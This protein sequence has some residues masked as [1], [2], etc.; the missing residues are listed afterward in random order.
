MSFNAHAIFDANHVKFSNM[1]G[2]PK[3]SDA[4]HGAYITP[5]YKRSTDEGVAIDTAYGE[6]ISD[7]QRDGFIVGF[8]A[9]IQLLMSCAVGDRGID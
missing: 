6:V 7:Y 2:T 5:A 4:F 9:A 8:N 1:A 3:S